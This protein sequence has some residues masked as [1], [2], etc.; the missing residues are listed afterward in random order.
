[1]VSKRCV[2]AFTLS[3][4]LLTG[5]QIGSRASGL[6]RVFV[7]AGIT[8]DGVSPIG[9]Y[10]SALSFT[11][12]ENSVVFGDIVITGS[13]GGV[14]LNSTGRVSAATFSTYTSGDV[15]YNHVV[16]S[17][18]P[19]AYLDL[20]TL[21]ETTAAATV[22]ITTGSDGSE[23]LAFQITDAGFTEVLAQAGTFPAGSIGLPPT[24]ELP[25]CGG[26]ATILL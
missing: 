20:N 9:V 18:S 2:L 5:L 4:A 22:Y 14:A 15:T 13:S 19:A 11:E 6:D 3:I 7:A 17:L 12:G 25:L 23:T 21:E 1:M 10:G 24:Q 26:S 16:L 8:L